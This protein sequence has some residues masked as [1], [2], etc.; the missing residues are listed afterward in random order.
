[1]SLEKIG[2]FERKIEKDVL[3]KLPVKFAE[4]FRVIPIEFTNGTL[5]VAAPKEIDTQVIEDIET[6]LE[7]NVKVLPCHEKEIDDAIQRYYGPGSESAKAIVS[8]MRDAEPAHVVDDFLQTKELKD[9]AG[10]APIIRLVNL[11][12]RKA[13]ERGAS[14]I[15]LEPYEKEVV[16]R[17]RVDGVLYDIESL[18][19]HV[20]PSLVSRIKIMAEMNIAEKRLPQDG[21]IQLKVDGRGI[22][23]RVATLPGLYGEGVVLR[24]LDKEGILLGLDDLGFSSDTLCEY[25]RLIRRSGG[26]I[27]VTGPTGSGKTTTL[28][29]SLNEIN[30]P[31]KKILTIEDPI[32]YQL[33]RVTQLAVKPRIGLSFANGLRSMLRQDPDIMMVGEI[34]DL[35][36][37]QIAIQSALT[38]HLIFSTLHT[39][40]APSTITRLVNMGIEPYLVASSVIGIIAQRLV[41][42]I[43]TSCKEEYR[44]Q[45]KLIEEFGIR[46]DKTGNVLWRGRGCDDCFGVGYKGRIGIFELLIID[47]PLREIITTGKVSA[48]RIREEGIRLGMRTLKEDGM[49]KVLAGIT[50]LDEVI[51]VTQEVG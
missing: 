6:M 10:E 25:K 32:E 47:D 48:A 15:H 36:T 51:K 18:P 49:E 40:D 9:G 4:R 13:V 35:E 3:A 38:G 42:K 24:I 33:E 31:E 1:V 30:T 21:R 45:H 12:I 11:F 43:C 26:V 28:Y 2:V 37:A 5:V 44:P 8:D 27:L 50:T 39:N 22:D 7:C 29:S 20:H 19:R 34:R 16:L 17:Y 41:R 14:D 46:L 23:I